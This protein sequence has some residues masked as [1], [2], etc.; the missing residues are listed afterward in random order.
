MSYDYQTPPG[1][2][3]RLWHLA[4][5][6][7][8]FKS[9]LVTYVVVIGML[10]LIW[11]FTGGRTYGAGLPWPAWATLGWGIGVMFH[12]LGAYVNTGFGSAENEYDKLTKNQNR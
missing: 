8:S 9:H 11:L 10:W 5:K 12:F 7:A 6:R 2:D 4:Q 3:P 1:R